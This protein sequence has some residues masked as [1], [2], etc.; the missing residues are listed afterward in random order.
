MATKIVKVE[1]QLQLEAAKEMNRLIDEMKTTMEALLARQTKEVSDTMDEYRRKLRD[2][3]VIIGQG[4]MADPLHA[5]MNGT[6]AIDSRYAD[7]GAV[8][9]YPVSKDGQPVD[10]GS[11]PTPAKPFFGTLN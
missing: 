7:F 11:A 3:Y 9:I 1:G 2:Q 6:H 10:D 8:F 5:Y 4:I